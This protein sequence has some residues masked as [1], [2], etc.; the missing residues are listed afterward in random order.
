MLSPASNAVVSSKMF[1]AS[2]RK[3][4]LTWS[5]R[6]L[7][8]CITSGFP[9]AVL[10]KPLICRASLALLKT[11]NVYCLG[12]KS[13]YAH[14]QTMREGLEDSLGFSEQ[15]VPLMTAQEIKQL[16]D[17]QI[18]GFHRRLPAFQAKRMDWRYF[19]QLAKRRNIPPPTP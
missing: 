15:G 1:C 11:D 17:D 14:S 19:P 10:L 13:G 4:F 18:I 7:A 16:R 12:K 6:L 8:A 9:A 2:P 5:W 3:A